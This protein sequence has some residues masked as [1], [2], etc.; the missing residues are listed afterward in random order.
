MSPIWIVSMVLQWIVIA[1]LCVL[2]LSLV[3][4][5]G[6]MAIK[7]NGIKENAES[8]VALYARVPRHDVPTVAGEPFRLGGQRPRPQL[9]VF[10]SPH[11]SACTLLPGALRDLASEGVNV[12]VLV[13]P[14]VEREALAD[15]LRAENLDAIT[16][17]ARDDFP[18]EYIPKI[19][20]PA[21]L[22]ITADG[23]VA[24]KGRPKTLEHLHE[25]IAAAQHMADLATSTST[26]QHEWGES[27]PY[28]EM[29]AA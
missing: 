18:E 21:A 11:C 23:V 19:G 27:A 4:Q 3:R 29:N 24:A 22:A 26:R 12:D 9:V 1:A 2:V 14:S 15:Y 6:E 17:A 5:I 25:M 8:S 10:F 28:W 16:A 20:V 13:L 7:L